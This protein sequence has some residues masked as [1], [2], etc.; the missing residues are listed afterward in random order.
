MH[1]LSLAADALWIIAL[2]IMASASRAAWE[3]AKP[4]ARVPPPLMPGMRV[5]RTVALAVG[6]GVGLV[7]GGVLLFLHRSTAPVGP[8]SLVWFC[9][10]A[11]TAALFAL[12]Y[13]R[14]LQAA[15]ETMQREEQFK[16]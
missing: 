2:S 11:I 6:P 1:V 15:L 12:G 14:Y 16:S 3:R 9:L 5:S 10:R 4:D 13:L 8:E 7:L